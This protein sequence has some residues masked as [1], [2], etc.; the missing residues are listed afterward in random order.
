MAQN[1]PKLT[2][3]WL[4]H[5]M[6]ATHTPAAAASKGNGPCRSS[7][8]SALWVE[9]IRT[10]QFP[11]GNRPP[12]H[13]R[14]TAPLTN[15]AGVGDRR[16]GPLRTQAG[17][18]ERTPLLPPPGFQPGHYTPPTRG[19]GAGRGRGRGGRGGAGRGRSGGGGSPMC[20]LYTNAGKSDNHPF[21]ACPLTTCHKCGQPEH[22]QR[23]CPN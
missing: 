18:G 9:R 2:A 15:P 16:T 6:S 11:H 8:I 7:R 10:N 1:Q 14:G 12:P 17:A 23:H 3:D 21:T 13:P 4:T 5:R 22:I 20:A 19:R